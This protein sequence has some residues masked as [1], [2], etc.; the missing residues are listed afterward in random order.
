VTVTFLTV[1]VVGPTKAVVPPIE[2][3]EWGL[4]LPPSQTDMSDHKTIKRQIRIF[5]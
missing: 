5:K 2:L 3:P 1:Q 4:P